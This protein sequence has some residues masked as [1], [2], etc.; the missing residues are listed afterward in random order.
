MRSIGK[1]DNSVNKFIKKRKKLV[2]KSFKN[3]KNWIDENQNVCCLSS[4]LN[5]ANPALTHTNMKVKTKQISRGSKSLLHVSR[6][7]LECIEPHDFDLPP[8]FIDSDQKVSSSLITSSSHEDKKSNSYS[9]SPLLKKN[10]SKVSSSKKENTTKLSTSGRNCETLPLEKRVDLEDFSS[11]KPT[12]SRMV[13][14]DPHTKIDALHNNCALHAA[15]ALGFMRTGGRKNHRNEREIRKNEKN[16]SSRSARANQRRILKEIAAFGYSTHGVKDALSGCEQSLRF[17]KSLIHGWGVFSD[18]YINAGDLI[19]EYRGILI[20]NALADK[21]EKEY[22][23]AKIGS[24]YMFRIDS[25]IVCDATHHGNLARFINASCSPN[26]YT[27]IITINGKKRIAI[28]AKKNITPGEELCYDY[29]FDPEFD[30]SQRI[31]CNCGSDE[32]RGYMNWDKRYVA[33]PGNGRK[34]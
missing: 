21:K 15:Q 9:S 10:K 33:I 11:F 8:N 20:G 22:E 14:Y 24:D 18:E 6:E 32:C 4:Y 31:C 7:F 30:E 5:E 23:K 26:C 17:G 12:C 34:H 1:V 27:Q 13:E 3:I 19:V 16:S 2:A 29:K 28:Y 25:E